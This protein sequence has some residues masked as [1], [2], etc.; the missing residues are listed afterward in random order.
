MPL[1]GSAPGESTG[2]A[3]SAWFALVWGFW[4]PRTLQ[5]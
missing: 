3:T 2:Y 5:A 1:R 4:E